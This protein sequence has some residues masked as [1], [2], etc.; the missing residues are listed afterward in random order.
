[1]HVQ[2]ALR[3]SPHSIRDDLGRSHWIGWFFKPQ[4]SQIHIGNL[5]TRASGRRAHHR[6]DQPVPL[7]RLGL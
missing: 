6:L 5:H 3:S 4:V 7:P 1:M 2:V